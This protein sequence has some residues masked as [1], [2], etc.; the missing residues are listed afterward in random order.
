MALAALTHLT[1]LDISGCNCSCNCSSG[2]KR[3]AGNDVGA[4]AGR[5][6]LQKLPLLHKLGTLNLARNRPPRR[7]NH[8]RLQGMGL[9]QL[10]RGSWLNPSL[11]C[12]CCM[13]SI[14]QVMRSL[15]RDQNAAKAIASA[16]RS[17]RSSLGS[18]HTT[19]CSLCVLQVQSVQAVLMPDG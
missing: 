14:Y 13:L 8:C 5:V 17:P 12:Q 18:G 7:A 15:G 11:F 3:C 4:K 9:E 16:A 19:A 2:S 10:P 1:A 6:V